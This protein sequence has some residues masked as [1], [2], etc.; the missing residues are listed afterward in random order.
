GGKWTDGTGMTENALCVDGRLTKVSEDLV[1]TYDTSDWLR[2]WRVRT[3]RSDQVDLTFTP[4]HDKRSRLSLGVL[5][6][7]VDQCFGTWSGT[8][9]PDGGEPLAVDGLFGWAEEAT[10]RWYAPTGCRPGPRVVGWRGRVCR[11]PRGRSARPH[12]A[13]RRRGR[14]IRCCGPGCGCRRGRQ[15]LNR[16]RRGA[17]PRLSRDRRQRP[18]RDSRVRRHPHP[19]RRPGLLGPRR[20]AFELARRHDRRHGQL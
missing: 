6:Q 7:A 3:P 2:P 11:P 9:V 5:S 14:V 10:W 4:I 20:H 17:R 1:W 12:H 18:C 15:P 8:I 16:R 13:Q 19:L